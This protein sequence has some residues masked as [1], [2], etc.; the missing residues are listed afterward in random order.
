ML[1]AVLSSIMLFTRRTMSFDSNRRSMVIEQLAER[2]IR[3]SRVLSAMERVPRERFVVTGQ[4]D[5]AYADRALSIECGQTISQPYIVALMTEALELEGAEN[6][7]EIGTGSGYQAAV[8]AELSAHVVTIE[9]HRELS[10]RAA[11][12]LA[13]LGYQN[14]T[15]IVGDGSEGW[16]ALA[17]Y[18]RIIVTAAAADVPPALV[19]QLAE[20]GVLVIP[21]GDKEGQVL[22]A[23]RKVNGRMQSTALSGCRFVP[24][25]GQFEPE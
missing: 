7:L 5:Q 3:N 1:T 22:E 16:A 15:L 18:D 8:L 9:R 24:L 25:V 13:G 23:L 14:V 4:E 6:V 12:V 11:A 2:G 19:E 17:P 10:E 21:L 20:G